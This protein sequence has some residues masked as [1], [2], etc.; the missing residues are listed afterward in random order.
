MEDLGKMIQTNFWKGK[1]VF[2]TGHTG[3][4]GAWLSIWLS[5]L[6][7]DVYGYAL[8]PPTNPN[9]YTLSDLKA[10]LV[11]STIGDLSDESLLKQAVQESDAEIVF[12]LAAQPIVRAS[13]QAPIKTFVDNTIGTARLLEA[14]RS[15][16]N[17]HAV[18]IITTDKCYENKEWFW[19]YRESDGLGGYD[20]Y[21]ASKACAEIVTS[22]YRRSFFNPSEYG[23]SHKV[24]IATV[25]AGNVIGGGDWARD[26]L[27]PDIIRA[28]DGGEKVVIRNPQAI[29]PW[30]HVLEPLHGYLMLA[31]RLFT[32]GIEYGE[33]W[34][35]GPDET[36][37]KPV[38][39]I[40]ESFSKLWK[41]APGVVLDDGEHPHEA[42]YLKLD[43]SKA[44]NR[45]G[46]EPVWNLE[47]ALQ[48]IF[49]WNER[50]RAGEDV[51]EVCISQIHDF[52]KAQLAMKSSQNIRFLGNRN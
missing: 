30:Q 15:L 44:K 33:A 18:V 29:R 38:S 13:Y 27:I 50:I 21:S 12:H 51:F 3:F 7:A 47:N 5:S 39:W 35:F 22:S 31:E 43:C 42:S 1:K 36:D 17:L 32:Y 2:I 26:R 8:T 19:P 41:N 46:W 52:E 9:I 20:P 28:F 4:K 6:G 23:K 37:A 45:L 40:V 48:K 49:E 25:R 16:K 11:R 24:G 34:N 14:L 10:H